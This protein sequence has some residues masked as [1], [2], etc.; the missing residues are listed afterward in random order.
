MH[1]YKNRPVDII[2]EIP[3]S[4][5]DRVVIQHHEPGLGTEIV[6]KKDVVETK[7][8]PKAHKDKK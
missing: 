1:T 8:T 7:E 6:P 2:Q 4:G 3:T 5:T